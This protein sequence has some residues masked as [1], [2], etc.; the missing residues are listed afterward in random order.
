MAITY[1][2]IENYSNRVVNIIVR[3]LVIKNAVEFVGV[4]NLDPRNYTIKEI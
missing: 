2:S 3:Y 1:L 4:L